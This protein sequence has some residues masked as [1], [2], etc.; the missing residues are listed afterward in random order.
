VIGKSGRVEIFVLGHDQA[1]LDAVPEVDGL[2][3][4]NLNSVS[5]PDRLT[6]QS[7]AEHRFLIDRVVDACEAEWIGI[8]TARWDEKFPNWPELGDLPKYA[9]G[10][11]SNPSFV[12]APAVF[13][14]LRSDIRR[15]SVRQDLRHPGMGELLSDPEAPPVRPS[16]NWATP[17]VYNNN[18][19]THRSVF[20]DWLHYWREQ[21]DYYDSRHG[22]SLPF[23]V[24]CP[25]CG[26]ILPEGSTHP[27]LS[28]APTRH[29]GYFYEQ[30]SARYFSLRDDLIVVGP[31]G[32]PIRPDLYQL[33][34]P[35]L[36]WRS[37]GIRRL[38]Q[39][40]RGPCGEPPTE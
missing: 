23:Q 37:P 36:Y 20:F 38:S 12:A 6:G 3:P 17:L 22:L 4:T 5:I 30:I 10:N 21:F 13:W 1:L 16:A 34:I 39:R 18:F 40:Y 27:G 2:T 28:Y 8:V 19:I 32:A 31:S 9:I 26:Q 15:F 11:L 25:K 14:W 35:T 24:A 33:A 29:A 7:L